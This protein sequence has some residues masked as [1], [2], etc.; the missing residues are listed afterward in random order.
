MSDLPIRLALVGCQDDVVVWQDVAMRLQGGQI[1]IVVDPDVDHGA[2]MAAA[3]GTSRVVESLE[4]ALGKHGSDFDA[5]IIRAPLDQRSHLVRLAAE[6]R[7]N[8]LVDSP[9][10]DSFQDAKTAIDSCEQAGVSF[11]IGQTMRF[12]PSNQLIM[13][14]LTSG[15]LGVPGLLRIHRWCGTDRG[16]GPAVE[17]IFGSVDF[18]LWVFGD[19]PV[20][21]YAIGRR[22]GSETGS[23]DYV[24]IHFGFPSGG[25]A[26][27][28][29]SSALP[30]GRGY[31]SVS[32]IGSTGAAYDDDHHN[33]QL[34]FRGG[35]PLALISDRGQRQ[36]VHELQAFVDGIVEQAASPIGGTNYQLVHQVLDAVDRS[37][38]LGKVLRSQGGNYEPA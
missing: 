4:V 37:L 33:T 34:L 10:A 8:V 23:P 38:E 29:F 22:V 32:L 15:K 26:L 11:A 27:L 9:I 16:Q 30:A 35:N 28:D 18:A 1:S 31:E 12:T 17:P 13:D 21:V 25:M 19:R 20:D 6:G 3:V 14:R 7:K 2:S 36:I 24:Q 5:V